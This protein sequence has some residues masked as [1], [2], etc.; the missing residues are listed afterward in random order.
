M[1]THDEERVIT[2][3]CPR[4]RKFEGI[5]KGTFPNRGQSKEEDVTRKDLMQTAEREGTLTSR[6]TTTE[7]GDEKLVETDDGEKGS[8]ESL[9][10]RRSAED[11][12]E[13][14]HRELR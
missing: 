8:L 12:L 11:D 7:E 10:L 3:R 13:V 2:S 14:R 4:W 1:K 9:W 5:V 6:V